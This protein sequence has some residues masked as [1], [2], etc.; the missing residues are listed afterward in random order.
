MIE[1]FQ[2]QLIK[3]L[4]EDKDIYRLIYSVLYLC[5]IIIIGI[6]FYWDTIYKNAKKYSKCNNISKIID[7]NYYNVTPYVYN[8]IIINTKKIKKPSEYIIKITYN[9][10][11]MIVDVSFGN[12]DGE[13]KIFMYRKNDYVGIIKTINELKATMSELNKLYKKSNDN[14]DLLLY[15]K[16]AIEY[17]TLINSKD[18][19]KALELNNDKDFINSFGYKYFNLEKMT[20]ETIEDISTQINS[21][22]YKYYAVDKNYNIVHSYTTNELIKFTKEYST[23]TNYPIAIIDYIIFSKIQ[24][25]N[26]INI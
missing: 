23:N 17:S 13:E 25:K 22:D 26:N 19:K 16:T 21:N 5:I 14:S 11:K 4:T 3:I 12:M 24:Q 10:N 8:I 18:G 6:F 9:F 15:N 7:D 1:D 20:Y 2:C